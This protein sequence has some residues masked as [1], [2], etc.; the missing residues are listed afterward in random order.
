MEQ[1]HVHQFEP[2]LHPMIGAIGAHRGEDVI[3]RLVAGR[4]VS[5]KIP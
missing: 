2:F 4:S 1:Q 5:V 3:T